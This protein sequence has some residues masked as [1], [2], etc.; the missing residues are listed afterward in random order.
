MQIP[1]HQKTSML[2][3]CQC[4]KQQVVR[5]SFKSRGPLV[6]LIQRLAKPNSGLGLGQAE[7]ILGPVWGQSA[8]GLSPDFSWVWLRFCPVTGPICSRFLAH[9]LAQFWTKCRHHF[10]IIS[11]LV[12]SR[13]LGLLCIDFLACSSHL[14][15]FRIFLG[16]EPG[17]KIA[18]KNLCPRAT[19][20]ASYALA[21][22]ELVSSST[23]SAP[24]IPS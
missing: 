13:L 7:P 6:G 14:G 20:V 11:G 5:F 15:L 3:A 8:A 18:I 1:S 4:I 19:Q 24:V 12:F 17:T 10:D 9:L 21:A 2:G 16:F 23:L 22:Y